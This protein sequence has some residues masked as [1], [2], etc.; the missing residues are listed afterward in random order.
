MTAAPAG[1]TPTE[2]ALFAALADGRPRP[3]RRLLRLLP[4][5]DGAEPQTL[6]QHL[7]NLRRKLPAGVRVFCDRGCYVLVRLT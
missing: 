2:R 6:R 5:P 7:S 1:L 3:A 4:D